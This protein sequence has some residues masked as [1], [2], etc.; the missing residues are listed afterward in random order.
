MQSAPFGGGRRPH[1]R[2]GADG[3]LPLYWPVVPVPRRLSSTRRCLLLPRGDA[4]LLFSSRVVA[5]TL[6]KTETVSF[7]RLF[8]FSGGSLLLPGAKLIERKLCGVHGSARGRLA[9]AQARQVDADH[10]NLDVLAVVANARQS[11]WAAE[12]APPPSP[13]QALLT[14]KFLEQQPDPSDPE[15][16]AARIEE[17]DVWLSRYADPDHTVL[18]K[19]FYQYG[20][21]ATTPRDLE[22]TSAKK[23]SF[24]L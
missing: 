22:S 21:G 14:G 18:F 13:D 15:E 10:A 24:K 17:L 19:K 23:A 11:D 6:Y 12:C 9:L 3:R 8:S 20:A 1:R 2:L 5:T 16:I 7:S 4:A